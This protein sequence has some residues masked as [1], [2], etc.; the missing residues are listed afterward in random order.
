MEGKACANSI[1]ACSIA[2]NAVILET[3]GADSKDQGMGLLRFSTSR[4]LP[5][6]SLN[7]SRQLWSQFAGPLPPSSLASMTAAAAAF[8]ASAEGA[9]AKVRR[10][11]S[12]HRA[13]V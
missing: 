12:C 7:N 3:C 4:I 10:G 9:M 5:T 2:E 6:P 1:L 11:L 8:V 13:K